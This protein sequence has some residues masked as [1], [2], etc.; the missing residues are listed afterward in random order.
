MPIAIIIAQMLAQYGP[1]LAGKIA[2]LLHS[3]AEPTLED[4]HKVLAQA[5]AKSYDDYLNAIK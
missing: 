4:W 2:T 1:E 5:S 3:Q